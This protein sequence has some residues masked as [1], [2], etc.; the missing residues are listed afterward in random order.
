ML[1]AETIKGKTAKTRTNLAKEEEKTPVA[2]TL[3]RF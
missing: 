1:T 2:N 3:S